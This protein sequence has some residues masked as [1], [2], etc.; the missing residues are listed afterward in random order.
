MA[1]CVDEFLSVYHKVFDE[2]ENI[3]PCGRRVTS[4]LIG[5]AQ[6]LEADTYFGN[7]E[8]G[9]MHVE[10]IHRLKKSLAKD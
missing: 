2:N 4:K 5:L 1:G 6:Q 8:T 9:Y 3:K 10:S 7:T